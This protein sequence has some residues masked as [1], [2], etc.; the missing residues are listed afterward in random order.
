MVGGSRVVASDAETPPCS[1]RFQM[2]QARIFN[3]SAR[4]DRKTRHVGTIGAGRAAMVHRCEVGYASRSPVAYSP[5]F[6]LRRGSHA[7]V[8]PFL[9]PVMPPERTER[10]SIWQ[11]GRTRR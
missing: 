1:T 7:R 10:R 2:S 4:F 3:L 9:G 6:F 5:P 8:V 11:N